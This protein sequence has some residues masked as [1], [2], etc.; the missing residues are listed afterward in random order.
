MKRHRNSSVVPL[1]QD[2]AQQTGPDAASAILREHGNIDDANLIRATIDI[3]PAN[4]S[5]AEHDDVKGRLFVILH[6][7]AVLEIELHPQ[8]H[9]PRLVLPADKFL[10]T[11]TG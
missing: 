10:L 6:I 5:S 1:Q 2:A 3:Q 7:L 8:E 11:G 9:F 4:W